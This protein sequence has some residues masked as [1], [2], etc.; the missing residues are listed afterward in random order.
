MV[1]IPRGLARQKQCTQA[2]PLISLNTLNAFLHNFL[3]IHLFH[4]H[5]FTSS[6]K[7]IQNKVDSQPWSP[8]IP[9][10]HSI[11]INRTEI[12]PQKAPSS[13]QHPKN[14]H[15]YLQTTLFTPL[16]PQ[17]PLNALTC[18]EPEKT[19]I[20]LSEGKSLCALIFKA[21]PLGIY[22]RTLD[23]ESNL[24]TLHYLLIGTK[25]SLTTNMYV[26]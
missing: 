5:D 2:L 9:I 25:F 12:I 22:S 23:Q 4:T 11:V 18:R 8:N 14:S 1:S 21:K 20:N 7:V 17:T 16:I 10:N 19:P 6:P 24:N 3:I 13:I 15:L 26:I